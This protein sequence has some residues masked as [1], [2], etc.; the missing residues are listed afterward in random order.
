M[1]RYVTGRIRYREDMRN[2]RRDFNRPDGVNGVHVRASLIS[3][4]NDRGFRPIFILLRVSALAIP[5]SS[6]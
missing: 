3:A 2:D 5:A 4:R 6:A 1:G